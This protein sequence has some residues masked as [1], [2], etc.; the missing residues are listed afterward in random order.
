MA[1]VHK[2]RSR[3][4]CAA[5]R[6]H[7][8]Q[9]SWMSRIEEH[10]ALLLSDAGTEASEEWLHDRAIAY[11]TPSFGFIWSKYIGGERKLI[12]RF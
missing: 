2:A 8:L 5:I 4:A 11:E 9:H 3:N 7:G 10:S 6:I 1:H 12:L